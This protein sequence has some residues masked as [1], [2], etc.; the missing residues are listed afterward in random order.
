MTKYRKLK[1]RVYEIIGPTVKGDSA[2]LVFDIILCLIVILSSL[3]V[4]LELI[5]VGEALHRLLND[6][7]IFTISFFVLEYILRIWVCEFEFP[8]A[9]SKIEAIKDFLTSFTSFVDLLAIGSILLVWIPKSLSLFRLI[10]LARLAKMLEHI[11][12][13]KKHR[14]K[15][16]WVKKRVDEIV[17]KATEGDTASLVYDII[18]VVLIVLSVSMVLIE[19]FAIPHA[20]HNLIYIFEVS[21]ACFF[22]LDYLLRVWVAPL[23]YPDMRPDKARLHYIF[24]LMAVIDF[25]SIFPI[26]VAS[27]SN[28]TGVFKIF[29]L[30]KIL[31]ILKITRYIGGSKEFRKTIKS[32]TKKMSISIISII[33]LITACSVF[34]FHYENSAQPEVYKN[35]FSG[36]LLTILKIFE[37]DLSLGPMTVGGKFFSTLM[38]LLGGC[39]IGVPA[40]IIFIAVENDAIKHHKRASENKLEAFINQYHALPEEDKEEARKII[41]EDTHKAIK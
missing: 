28:A 37:S 19:T 22:A 30:C 38:L 34:V 7:E 24:S 26:F 36:I 29:K 18:S 32:Q 3:A 8:K 4:V 33:V 23:D 9:K 27:I 21:I 39:L 31:R 17:C 40:S 16:A 2:S 14:E 41:L 13:S 6:F 12:F 10:K 25:A 20:L 11:N 5:G 15:I 35:G 1:K